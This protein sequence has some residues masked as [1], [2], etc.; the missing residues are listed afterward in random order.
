MA[1]EK[2]RRLIGRTVEVRWLDS[3]TSG[4][5]QP[6]SQLRRGSMKLKSAGYLV[7]ASKS[8]IVVSAAV[9]HNGEA[10]ASIIIPRSAVLSVKRLR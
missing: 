5:W 3:F 10:A 6:P 9:G 4:P 2:I 1:K 7:A 8:R